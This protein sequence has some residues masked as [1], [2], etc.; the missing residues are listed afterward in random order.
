MQNRDLIWGNFRFSENLPHKKLQNLLFFN[1]KL[2]FDVRKKVE[3]FAKGNICCNIK[4]QFGRI[5]QQTNVNLQ[6]LLCK[7]EK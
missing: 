1:T 4:L 5:L 3:I 2:E 6:K 7:K